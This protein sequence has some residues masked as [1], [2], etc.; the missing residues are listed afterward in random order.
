MGGGHD[1]ARGTEGMWGCQVIIDF[2][3]TVGKHW[4]KTMTNVN[5]TTFAVGFFLFF[6]AITPAITFGGVYQNLTANRSG[7]VEMILASTWCGVFYTLF[8]G[9]ASHD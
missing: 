7:A 1:E 8:C 3:N 5:T 6:A 2:R 4:C 9:S